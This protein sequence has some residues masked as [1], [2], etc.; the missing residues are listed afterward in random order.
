MS[1][2]ALNPGRWGRSPGAMRHACRQHGR[3]KQV[4]KAPR[5]GRPPVTNRGLRTQSST[6]TGK[7]LLTQGP[8]IDG[9]GCTPRS[10]RAQGSAEK[11]VEMETELRSAEKPDIKERKRQTA[12]GEGRG[13]QK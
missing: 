12:E 5:T 1:L 8:G 9:R 10:A 7:G 4:G 2:P 3:V 11:P 6:W 13:A